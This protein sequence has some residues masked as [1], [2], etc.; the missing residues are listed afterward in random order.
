MNKI[1]M[2]VTPQEARKVKTRTAFMVH[3]KTNA[4]QNLTGQSF[5]LRSS[6]AGWDEVKAILGKLRNDVICDLTKYHKILHD[7]VRTQP[8]C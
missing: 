7:S 8:T 4:L 3:V 6:H 1:K 2:A 5:E